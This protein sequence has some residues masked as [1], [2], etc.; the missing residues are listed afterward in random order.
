MF[1]SLHLLLPIT[2]HSLG[3]LLITSSQSSAQVT[4]DGTVNTQVTQ[5][6]NVAEI[7]GGE[8]RGS[9]L[10]H[11]FQDFSVGTDNEAFFNNDINVHIVIVKF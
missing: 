10:F 6:A 2:F 1:K 7:T 8:T 3:F 5:N 11:S 4:S 9:N